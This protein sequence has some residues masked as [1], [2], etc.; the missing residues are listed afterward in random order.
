M[1]VNRPGWGHRSFVLQ[2]DHSGGHRVTQHL[3]RRGHLLRGN[4]LARRRIQ[5]QAEKSDQ[6][7]RMYGSARII[8][9]VPQRSIAFSYHIRISPISSTILFLFLSPAPLSLS[10]SLFLLPL[11][12]LLPS[13]PPLTFGRTFSIGSMSLTPPSS[14]V[15]SSVRGPTTKFTNLR[16]FTS[17]SSGLRST[18]LSCFRVGKHG[19]CAF[20]IILSR[21][22]HNVIR[23][24]RC[25][26]LLHFPC[27]I[28]LPIRWFTSQGVS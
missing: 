16:V 14:R 28:G 7:R 18:V 20:P 21:L 27:F 9:D 13:P 15:R 19:F 8:E 17:P 4:V 12:L 3:R 5:S 25:T 6:G 10:S 24:G 22:A 2:R 23:C 1:V 11:L 26:S